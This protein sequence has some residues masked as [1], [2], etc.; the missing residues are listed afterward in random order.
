MKIKM[1]LM[2]L[3]KD[4][5]FVG[6]VIWLI[7]TAALA[8]LCIH[9][10]YQYTYNTATA[11]VRW[12]V[13]IFAAAMLSGVISVGINELWFR[14]RRKRGSAKRKSGKKAAKGRAR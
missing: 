11:I 2:K 13:G 14:L 4:P 8:P 10:M 7:I 3:L 9:L 1:K 5:D 6:W 12:I